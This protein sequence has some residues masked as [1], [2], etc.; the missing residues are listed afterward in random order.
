MGSSSCSH[1]QLPAR[2]DWL[3]FFLPFGKRFILGKLHSLVYLFCFVVL[4][5]PGEKNSHEASQASCLLKRMVTLE[6]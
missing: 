2:A 5:L 4:L 6:S 3:C 1:C